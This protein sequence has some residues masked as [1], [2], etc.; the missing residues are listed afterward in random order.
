MGDLTAQ[1]AADG[2]A[3][4]GNQHHLPGN[5]ARQ[6]I[7]VHPH[8]LPAQQVLGVHLPQ[9][10]DAD[11]S[12]EHLIDAGKHMD[13]TPGSG[14]DVQNLF[15]GNGGSAGDGKH[16][17]VDPV[18]L[19]RFGNILPAAHNGD[20]AEPAV[21]LRGVVVYDADHFIMDK[22]T[23]DILGDQGPAGL[24][25]ADD[26]NSLD[27]CHMGHVAD[28]LQSHPGHAVGKPDSHRTHKA[29]QVSHHH[30]GAGNRRTVKAKDGYTDHGKHHISPGDAE[31]LR[32]ADI[33]PNAAVQLKQGEHQYRNGAPG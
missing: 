33:Y 31:H 26:H 2:A 21:Y 22:I 18:A 25:R 23:V 20:S 24:S 3:A 11:L 9:L 17:L 32:S 28:L 30:A 14:A 8:R 6:F 5:V 19:H 12:V 13:L 27:P 7:Q 10:A 4:A 1:L 29:E 16:D 15:P